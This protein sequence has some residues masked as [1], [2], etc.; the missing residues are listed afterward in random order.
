MVRVEMESKG[1]NSNNAEKSN[2]PIW[3]WCLDTENLVHRENGDNK[4]KKGAD[5]QP[6]PGISTA[7]FHVKKSTPVT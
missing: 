7:L 2:K 3:R 5:A 4:G 1:C 6:F